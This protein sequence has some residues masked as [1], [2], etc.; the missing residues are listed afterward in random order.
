MT[1][2]TLDRIRQ[3]YGPLKAV[4]R[5]TPLLTSRTLDG[6]AGGPV[7]FKAEN[8]Q[9]TGSFKIRGA[10]TA[11]S[12]LVEAERARGVV[13]ASA[14][15]HAQGIALA[16][17]TSGSRDPPST[18]RSPPRRTTPGKRARA[19]SRRSTTTTSSPARA[20]SPSNCWRTCPTSTRS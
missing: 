13:T 2:I 17:Q 15:N 18:T 12:R 20:A 14:G 7:Q 16:A 8:L 10:Y 3:A 9:K 11:L 6:L 5:R 19:S 1:P 4:V